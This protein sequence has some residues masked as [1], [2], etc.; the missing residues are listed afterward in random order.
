MR[1]LKGGLLSFSEVMYYLLVC[2]RSMLRLAWKLWPMPD[3]LGW[4]STPQFSNG[5]NPSKLLNLA[6]SPFFHCQNEDKE[7]KKVL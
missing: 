1:F 2:L 4:N 5:V 7:G 3:F 6:S